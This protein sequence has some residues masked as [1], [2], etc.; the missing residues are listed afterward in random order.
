MLP[1]PCGAP[2]HPASQNRPALPLATQP[3]NVC[4]PYGVLWRMWIGSWMSWYRH[5]EIC[6]RHHYH[7]LSLEEN[8]ECRKT[9]RRGEKLTEIFGMSCSTHKLDL[10]Y[11]LLLRDKWCD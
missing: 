4:L 1:A 9:C 11:G 7:R 2:Q 3:Q 8:M 5:P 6:Q 10:W